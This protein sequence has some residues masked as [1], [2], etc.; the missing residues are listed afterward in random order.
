[1][2]QDIE[3]ISAGTIEIRKSFDADRRARFNG[4]ASAERQRRFVVQ[5]SH[6]MRTPLAALRLELEEA[7]T[8]R[9]VAD[10]F[11]ALK[12]AL[13]SVERLENTVIAL[14]W[15]LQRDASERP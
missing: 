8:N 7:L 11:A 1:M 9:D 12:E 2:C 10:P 15:S 4:V 14:L 5:A 13:Q 6:E 3:F